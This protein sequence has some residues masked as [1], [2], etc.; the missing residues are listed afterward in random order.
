MNRPRLPALLVGLLSV[1]AAG[2]AAEAQQDPAPSQDAE[3][4]SAPAPPPPVAFVDLAYFFAH[5]EPFHEAMAEIKVEV[6]CANGVVN[7]ENEALKAM[8]QQLA[9][10][11]AGT[12]EYVEL[13]AKITRRTAE[14]GASVQTQKAAFVRREAKVYWDTYQQLTREVEAYAREHRLVMVVRINEAPPSLVKPEEILKQINRELIWYDPQRDITRLILQ[15]MT[16]RAK[17][18]EAAEPSPGSE[19]PAS[20]SEGP[21]SE[22]EGPAPKADEPEAPPPKPSAAQPGS[23]SERKR[24]LVYFVR[25]TLRA[26]PAK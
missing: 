17:S 10:L 25:S 7:A 18:G 19:E 3:T 21:T 16:E 11:G 1:L 26:V 12:P 22:N 5:C 8:Q 15:R 6:E 9:G 13:E 23:L 4:T 14:L 20:E 24:D 2:N